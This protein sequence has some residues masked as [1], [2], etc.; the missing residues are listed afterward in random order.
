MK[1]YSAKPSE[2]ERKWYVVDASELPLGRLSTQVASLL[3]G[4]GKPMFTS[5]VDCGDYVVVIN[6]DQLV[7]TG[8][9]REGKVYYRHSGYPGGLKEATLNEKMATDSTQV[10]IHAIRGMIPANKLRDGRLARLKVYAGAEHAH[11]A[12]QPQSI[13]FKKDAK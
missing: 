5:H 8:N 10:I 3:T 1:T 12:Q 9:K 2:V 4:K 7:V 11:T 6:A 13:S